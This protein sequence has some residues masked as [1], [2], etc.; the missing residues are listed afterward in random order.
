M[1]ALL[2]WARERVVSHAAD[3]A[4]GDGAAFAPYT[5]AYAKTRREAGLGTTPDLRRTGRMLGGVA[6]Q[7]DA[8]VGTAPYTA[9]VDRIRPFFALGS[10][11]SVAM[12]EKVGALVDEALAESSKPA[13]ATRA[14]L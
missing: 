12:D 8:L 11:D 7:G 1:A 2:E 9:E 13:P 6:V 3:G 10:E 5:P 14:V 4:D